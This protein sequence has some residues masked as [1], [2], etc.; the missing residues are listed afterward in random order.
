MK[1]T[2]ALSGA[3]L[4]LFLSACGSGGKNTGESAEATVLTEKDSIAVNQILVPRGIMVKGD[5]L[6]ISADSHNG[7]DT[8]FYAYS[9]PDGKFL[10]GQGVTGE[11]PNDFNMPILF[12]NAQ[13]DTSFCAYNV[14]QDR[15]NSYAL[16]KGGFSL[17]TSLRSRQVLPRTEVNDSIVFGDIMDWR[18][19][20]V[21]I[22][23]ENIKSGG[24][25]DSIP[26]FSA[27]RQLQYGTSFN[28]VTN[29]F[30]LFGSGNKAAVAYQLMDRIEFYDISPDGKMTPVKVL[31]SDK[32]D[33]KYGSLD[34]T[35]NKL[36]FGSVEKYFE[37]GY[38]TRD[39]LYV[40]NHRGA[41]SEEIYPDNEDAPKVTPVDVYT[42]DGQLVKR[43]V[44]PGYYGFA[45]DE[46][47]HTIYAIEAWSD[48]DFTKIYTFKYEL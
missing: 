7:A 31:G 10:F 5:I 16:G 48:E 15:I 8:L 19:R 43:L 12:S 11:G 22:Y 1:N 29:S 33:S 46:N 36:V 41:S 14:G 37:G 39:H 6:L 23:T 42:W 4:L 47:R 26:T 40:I 28:S 20:T 34:D 38:A 45:V 35:D 24:K 27:I 3:A 13:S 17:L 9:I 32:L 18:A 44:L 30:Y 21:G 25:T 2:L